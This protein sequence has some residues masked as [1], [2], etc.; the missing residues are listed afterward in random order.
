M[1]T[2]GKMIQYHRVVY[3]KLWKLLKIQPRPQ[4]QCSYKPC[5]PC[6]IKKY[7]LFWIFDYIFPLRLNRLLSL[8]KRKTHT[9]SF[10][11]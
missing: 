7:T 9:Y 3:F 11:K 6:T 5:F 4:E 8:I 2:T 10:L 1:T